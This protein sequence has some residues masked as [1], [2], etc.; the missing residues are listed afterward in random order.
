MASMSTSIWGQPLANFSAK[1]PG[2]QFYQLN[3]AGEPTPFGYFYVNP[4]VSTLIWQGILHFSES[5][6][7][8]ALMALPSHIDHQWPHDIAATPSDIG[9]VTL[10]LEARN[11][12]EFNVFQRE[13]RDQYLNTLQAANDAISFIRYD[14]RVVSSLATIEYSFTAENSMWSQSNELTILLPKS[15]PWME[16]L[17]EWV[18]EH[19][20][21]VRT[22]RQ[23][24]KPIDIAET[25]SI[26]R[27]T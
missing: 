2:E 9:K 12:F 4:E 1:Q 11:L 5:L 22:F 17:L 10:I 13:Q 23:S 8:E 20:E 7:H 19:H 27:Y 3:V 18:I 14:V 15:Q 21:K 24:L 25:L 6:D 16:S 26:L